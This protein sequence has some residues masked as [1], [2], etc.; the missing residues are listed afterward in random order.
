MT[1]PRLFERWIVVAFWQGGYW[2]VHA[3]RWLTRE[4]IIHLRLG[5]GAGD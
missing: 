4:Y 1:E 3:D 5:G 2:K